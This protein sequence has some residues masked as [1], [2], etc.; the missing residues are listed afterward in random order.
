M[1]PGSSVVPKRQWA[2]L[3]HRRFILNIRKHFFTVRV[4]EHWNQLSRDVVEWS[5]LEILKSV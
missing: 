1:A 2:K 3:K 4:T 5:S